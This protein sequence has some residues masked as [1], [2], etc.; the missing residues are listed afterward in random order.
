MKMQIVLGAALAVATAASADVI[1]QWNFNGSSNTTVPGG[2]NSPTASTGSGTASLV[3]GVTAAAQFGSGAANGG[4]SDPAGGAP[5]NYGW[6][7]TSYAAQGFN[8]DQAGVQFNVSTV[9]FAS[10]IVVTWD[11]RHSNTSSRWVQFQY[12]LDGVNFTSAGLSGGG[13]FE[14]TA[15]DTWFN[16][17]TVDLSGIAGVANNAN[18][19]FRIVASFGPTGGYEASTSTASYASSGTWRFDMVTVNGTIPAPGALALFVCA[20][21]VGSRRRRAAAQ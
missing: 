4:S 16:G 5:P 15:G 18:F 1:T 13:L 21:L 17:R 8:D 20:G 3:G 9:G 19:A 6:Q 12:S 14:G 2:A 11:Q 7:T 10:D